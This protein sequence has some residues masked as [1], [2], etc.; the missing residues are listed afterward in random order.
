MLC[1]YIATDVYRVML[2]AEHLALLVHVL[3]DYRLPAEGSLRQMR[4]DDGSR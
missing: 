4:R 1:S 2:G 3:D